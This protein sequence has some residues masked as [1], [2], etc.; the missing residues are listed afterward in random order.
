MTVCDHDD[1][2]ANIVIRGVPEPVLTS[3]RENARL[4]HQSFGDY[5]RS[6]IH[7]LA[8]GRNLDAILEVIDAQP[9]GREVFLASDT[10]PCD[11]VP[12]CITCPR[13]T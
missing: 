10:R 3:L 11:P 12:H 13:E 1:R 6:E 8:R 7:R 2:L 4:R 9:G 5:L